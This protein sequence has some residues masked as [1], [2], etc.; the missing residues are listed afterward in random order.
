M[1]III[2]TL[3]TVRSCILVLLAAG[4]ASKIV[5]DRNI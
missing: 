3:K 4:I 1:I 2:A 5:R